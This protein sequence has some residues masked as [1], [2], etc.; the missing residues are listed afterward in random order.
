MPLILNVGLSKKV[1]LPNY[2][3]LGVSCHLEVELDAT[4]L[5][6]DV[7]GFQQK[8]KQAY[9]ACHQAVRE[10]LAR[11]EQEPPTNGNGN[12]NGA[13]HGNGHD[14]GMNKVAEPK[15]VPTPRRTRDQ[16]RPATANQLRA[17]D[18]IAVRQQLDLA[19]LLRQRFGDVSAADLTI[20]EASHL[21][22]ELN[23]QLQNAG[24]ER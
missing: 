12:G 6:H 23:S 7:N 13:S 3:S 24:V 14:P 4:L 20:T 8:V 22:D 5:A 17:L 19:S 16:T 21:I 2:G 11:Q 15:Q 1:G 10:E 9:G 18:A